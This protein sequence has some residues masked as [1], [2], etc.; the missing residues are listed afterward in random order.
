[1]TDFAYSLTVILV[2]L[3]T[4]N[5]LDSDGI[6]EDQFI[7]YEYQIHSDTSSANCMQALDATGKELVCVL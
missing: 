6:G 1:M 7:I 4:L 5:P 2:K 3:L